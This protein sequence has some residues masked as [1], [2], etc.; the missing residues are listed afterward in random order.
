MSPRKTQAA[1]GRANAEG[2]EE[3]IWTEI[4][5]AFSRPVSRS[6]RGCS[7]APTH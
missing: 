2:R 1:E 4:D 5:N 3:A 7:H 6:D